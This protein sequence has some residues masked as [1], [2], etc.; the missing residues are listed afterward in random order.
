MSESLRPQEHIAAATL[1]QWRA[2][3]L[4]AGE[5]AAV[6]Q[7]L[8]SCAACQQRARMLGRVL[9]EMRARHHAAQPALAEQMHLLAALQTEFA[10]SQKS[11]ALVSASQS[12]VRWLAPALA[13]L[14]A[15]FV[16]WREETAASNSSLESLL[17]PSREEQVLM[18][19]DEETARQALME[20]AFS[21]E[22]K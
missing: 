11:R 15:L 14:A 5:S 17:A 21:T 7:H 20:L 12:V 19:S 4:G 18:A 3:E 13:V 16:L 9:H 1:W 10:P 22:E 8:Q 2:Q 6:Q